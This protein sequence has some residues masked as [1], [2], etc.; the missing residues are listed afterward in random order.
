[1]GKTVSFFEDPHV[2]GYQGA[3]RQFLYKKS[4]DILVFDES[5]KPIDCFGTFVNPMTVLA[6]IDFTK[7]NGHKALVHA[8]AASNLG[9][10]LVKVAK[11]EGIPLVNIVRRTEQ[12]EALESI[13]AEHVL[14]S[15]SETFEEDLEKLAE[16]LNVTAFFDPIGADFTAKVLDR[17]P[18]GST[19]YIYGGLGGAPVSI[20]GSSF[21]FFDKK[22]QGLWLGPWLD[23]LT[24]AER[25]AVYQQVIDDL[26]K[27][28]EI[29]G[30]KV[31]ETYPITKFEE[32]INAAEGVA[33]DGKLIINPQLS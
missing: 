17:L 29:F 4:T 3:W 24:T 21:I 28:G 20:A 14:N 15:T 16:T 18:N 10:M 30:S 22:I 1:M 7:K 27:G 12:V 23:S 25:E 19:A 6:I 13:G 26:S 33:S 11:K 8:A 2:K 5:V 9:K 31:L 32:A